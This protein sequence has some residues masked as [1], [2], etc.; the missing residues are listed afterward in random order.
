MRYILID[1][2]NCCADEISGKDL[3]QTNAPSETLKEISEFVKD[4]KYAGKPAEEVFI[5]KVQDA[6]YE[7]NL[8]ASMEDIEIHSS[9]AKDY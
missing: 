7:I 5:D 3:A 9:S 8:I 6:G 1:L 2:G 4:S